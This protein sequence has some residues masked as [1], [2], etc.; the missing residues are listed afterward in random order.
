[1]SGKILVEALNRLFRDL[2]DKNQPFGGTVVVLDGDFRQLPAVK[3]GAT[4]ANIIDS[5]IKK[6]CHCKHSK[7]M[8][9]HENMRVKNRGSD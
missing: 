4:K 8:A 2:M 6:Y 5:S 7:L 9:L 1:M 3:P